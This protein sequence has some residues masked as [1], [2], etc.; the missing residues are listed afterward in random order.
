MA[1]HFSRLL[2]HAW[3]YGGYILDLNPRVPTGK[4]RLGYCFTP[5]QRLWPYNG[6]PLVAFYDTLGIRRT[7]SRLKPPASSRGV[8]GQGHEET[9]LEKMLYA[10]YS[11]IFERI[12][13]KLGWY[14]GSISSINPMNFKVRTPNLM[15]TVRQNNSSIHILLFIATIS[16][17][18]FNL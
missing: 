1:P 8:T 11:L 4:V 10:Y 5:Y 7:Y 2:R 18:L 17:D 9:T 15:V 13:V 12:S 16:Q 6:A 14:I 3:G